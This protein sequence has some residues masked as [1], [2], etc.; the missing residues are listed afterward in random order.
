MVSI[1]S[2]KN[3]IKPTSEKGYDPRK[4]EKQKTDPHNL[5]IHMSE[6]QNK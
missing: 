5:A 1:C 4:Q 6:P 2:G 3:D